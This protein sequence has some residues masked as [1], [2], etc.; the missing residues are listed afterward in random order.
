MMKESISLSFELVIETLVG[1]GFKPTDAQVYIFLAKKGPQRGKDL[2]NSLKI[3]KQQLYPSLKNLQE[4]GIV[5]STHERPAIFS[6]VSVEKVL[7]ALIK[8]KIEETERMIQNKE[9]LISSWRLMPRN[10]SET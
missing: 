3:T 10:N 2:V 8:T 7:D 6:A 9:K 1:F 4:R 5:N